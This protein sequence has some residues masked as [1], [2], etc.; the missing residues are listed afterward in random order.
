MF[1]FSV[2]IT[3]LFKVVIMEEMYKLCDYTWSDTEKYRKAETVNSALQSII[4][5]LIG[6]NLLFSPFT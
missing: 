5:N 2:S 1:I 3:I 4:L 6:I